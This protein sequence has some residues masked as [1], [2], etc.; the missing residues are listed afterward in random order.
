MDVDGTA[1]LGSRLNPIDVDSFTPAHSNAGEGSSLNPIN[2]DDLEEED[3][4]AG[5]I[6]AAA[7]GKARGTDEDPID[8]EQWDSDDTVY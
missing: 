5:R 7:K 6:P 4:T 8:V 2:V 3:S 1:Q